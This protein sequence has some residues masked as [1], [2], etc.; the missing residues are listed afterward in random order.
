MKSEPMIF[1]TY[2]EAST[3]IGVIKEKMRGLDIKNKFDSNKYKNLEP[4]LL[5]IDKFLKDEDRKVEIKS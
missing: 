2:F 3:L 1:I 5:K 4:I